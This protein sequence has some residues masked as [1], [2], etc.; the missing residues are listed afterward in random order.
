[1]IVQAAARKAC[2]EAALVELIEQTSDDIKNLIHRI[3][4]DLSEYEIDSITNRVFALVWLRGSSY[5]GK[6]EP[7]RDPDLT[8]GAW[9]EKIIRNECYSYLRELKRD[10]SREIQEADLTS[11][12]EEEE[13][14]IDTSKLDYQANRTLSAC[15][16]RPIEEHLIQEEQFQAFRRTLSDEQSHILEQK[17]ADYSS[18]E[19]A[20]ELGVSQPAISQKR[21]S[22]KRKYR[23]FIEDYDQD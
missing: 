23:Q 9:L 21:R 3:A 22:I 7:G 14:R 15:Q 11:S 2:S 12:T 18:S 1:M 19:I 8:A 5:S 16:E 10:K 13:N 20:L 4:S 17:L 6:T